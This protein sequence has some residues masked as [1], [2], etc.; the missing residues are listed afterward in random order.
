VVD[1]KH[2]SFIGESKMPAWVRALNFKFYFLKNRGT[3]LNNSLKN[4]TRTKQS[5]K[6]E[7]KEEKESFSFYS[8]L[9]YSVI[10]LI[11]MCGLMQLSEWTD[12]QFC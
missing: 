4:A 7:E 12:P 10:V 5:G 1:R 2:A 8:V 9:Q 11:L 6:H 3:D